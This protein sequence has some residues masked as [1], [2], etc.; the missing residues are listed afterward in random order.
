MGTGFQVSWYCMY[1]VR[2]NEGQLHTE[3]HPRN[4]H[5]RRQGLSFLPQ[6]QEGEGTQQ[7]SLTSTIIEQPKQQHTQSGI[8]KAPPRSSAAIPMLTRWHL[9]PNRVRPKGPSRPS[10]PN[11]RPPSTLKLADPATLLWPHH[12]CCPTR[13][14]SD[15]EPTR[16]CTLD[17]SPRTCSA[18]VA[19]WAKS[20]MRRK[21]SAM[22]LT[23]QLCIGKVQPALPTQTFV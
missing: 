18:T 3:P 11:I 4:G 8:G 16:G 13:G 23:S 7:T 12:N 15:R 21:D 20:S 2:T 14:S 6:F 10:F 19:E 1:A 17:A 22:V 5:M 9:L